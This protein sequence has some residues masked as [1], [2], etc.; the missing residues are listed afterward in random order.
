MRRHFAVLSCLAVALP[1]SAQTPSKRW[2]L[3]GD[4]GYV[5]VSG[6]QQLTTFSVGDRATY[7]SG[8]FQFSQQF[9]AVYSEA[10]GNANA[11][12]YR[13]LL[14]TD[15]TLRPRLTTYGVTTWDRNRFAGIANKYEQQVGLAWKAA[16]AA[17]DTLRI[18]S[19]AG[20]IQQMNLDRSRLDFGASRSAA[21]Y[22]HTFSDRSYVQQFAEYILNLQDTGDH[23]TNTETSVVAPLSRNAS[24]KLGYLV[25]YQSRPPFRPGTTPQERF[26]TTDYVFTS[27]LQLTW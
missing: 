4:V 6:N 12:F 24:V 21:T 19:G 25:R 23:R 26:R 2:T 8:R 9:N 27:G 3:S 7:R 1:A 11:E 14:R 15:L 22:K 13:V 10:G 18:E 16:E 17:R 20:L 5:A